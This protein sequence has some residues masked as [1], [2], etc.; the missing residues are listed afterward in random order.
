MSTRLTSMAAV[1]VAVVLTLC[2]AVPAYADGQGGGGVDGNGGDTSGPGYDIS[3][4]QCNGAF[5][6]AA[7]FGIVGVDGGRVHL[8]NPCLGTDGGPSELAWAVATGAP[9]LYANTG[10]PGPA[11]SRY[12][13]IAGW[14]DYPRAC[15]AD[16]PNSAGCSY[17]YGWY[18][19]QDS[20]T[21]ATDAE[22]QLSPGADARAAAAAVPWWLDVETA[23]SWQAL[24]QGYT[25]EQVT[26]QA[27]DVAALQGEVAY[28]QSQGVSQVG[29]YSTAY[30]WRLITGGALF[31]PNASWVAGF[32]SEPDAAAGCAAPSGFTGGEIVLTQYVD[33]GADVDYAC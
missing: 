9:Q 33:D 8:A 11:Y 30:Q 7:A 27:N 32:T 12:W 26:A 21:T 5:P 16:D 28:L 19:A 31:L 15:S 22:F 3:Y 13:D 18:A 6:S 10:D 23:N 24:E 29:V 1:A 4:P 14:N 25:D 2:G 20:F 17:D